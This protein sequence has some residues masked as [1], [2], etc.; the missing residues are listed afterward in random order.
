M[1]VCA[2]LE[3]LLVCRYRSANSIRDCLLIE[4]TS[5]YFEKR[6]H[7]IHAAYRSY[8]HAWLGLWLFP[9]EGTSFEYETWQ[10]KHVCYID[11]YS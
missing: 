8:Y 7:G 3:G 2:L 6:S 4:Q 9:D 1:S 10:N 5:T 11:F